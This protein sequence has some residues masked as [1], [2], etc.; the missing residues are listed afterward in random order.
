MRV[1]AAAGPSQYNA[2]RIC[3]VSNKVIPTD[4]VC[5]RDG[6]LTAI[7]SE[8]NQSPCGCISCFSVP[9]SNCIIYIDPPAFGTDLSI[10]LVLGNLY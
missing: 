5:L 3:S 4:P 10:R 2:F 8:G 9:V 6:T 7:C 1:T